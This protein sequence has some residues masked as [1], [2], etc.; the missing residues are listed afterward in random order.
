M[1]CFHDYAKAISPRALARSFT[2]RYYELVHIFRYTTIKLW[3]VPVEDLKKTG[4][5][6]L[7][8][9]CLLAKDGA[10]RDVAKEVFKGTSGNKEL[11]ALALTLASMVFSNDADQQWLEREVAMLEDIVRDTWFYQKILKE[12]REEGR[13][14]AII[15]T[16]RLIILDTVKER[17]PALLE[18][19]GTRI[20]E[21]SDPLLLRKL[22][23]RI[24]VAQTVDE[25][26]RALRDD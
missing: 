16:L 18:L 8:P 24:V 12:G 21:M 1:G 7:L 19:A 23:T 6:G 13:E 3:E 26:G 15:E 11:L 22:N 14:E 9:L 10:R 4:L 5:K 2:G 25:A 17:F 20:E